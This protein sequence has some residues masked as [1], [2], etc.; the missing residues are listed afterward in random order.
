MKNPREYTLTEIEA[1]ASFHGKMTIIS[2][3]KEMQEWIIEIEKA[4]REYEVQK[5]VEIR[6]REK[7]NGTVE[8]RGKS[9]DRDLLEHCIL[10]SE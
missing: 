8:K 4:Q 3:S 10:V 6:T 7:E 5:V 2:M 9:L 1:L